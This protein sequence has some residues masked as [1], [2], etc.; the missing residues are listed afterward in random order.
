MALHPGLLIGDRYLL[1]QQI[2]VGGMGE[3]WE[4]TDQLLGRQVAVKLLRS[5]FGSDKEF[6]DRFRVEAR[7]AGVINHRNIAAVHDYGEDADAPDGATA[8]LVMEL[9]HGEPLSTRLSNRGRLGAAETLAVLE[10]AGRALQAAH[11]HGFVHRDVKPGNILLSSDDFDAD[12]DDDD[13]AGADAAAE[14]A[15]GTA[16]DVPA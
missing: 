10:Q 8:F 12:D 11:G 13:A 15:E 2:A 14:A 9:V 7:T 6:I 1:A 4:A 16:D 3:V 5:E